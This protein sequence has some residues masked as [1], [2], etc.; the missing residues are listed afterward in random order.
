MAEEPGSVGLKTSSQ[1]S[2]RVQ[3]LGGEVA[4]DDFG[5]QEH[6]WIVT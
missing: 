4:S 5:L 2:G 1:L 6:S 3:A